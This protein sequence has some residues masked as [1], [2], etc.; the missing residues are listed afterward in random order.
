[1]AKK[2]QIPVQAIFDLVLGYCF[3]VS[4]FV[5][6]NPTPAELALIR[7]GFDGVFNVAQT[8]TRARPLPWCGFSKSDGTIDEKALKQCLQSAFCKLLHYH[9]GRNSAY[10]GTIINATGELNI[11]GKALGLAPHKNIPKYWHLPEGSIEAVEAR[12]LDKENDEAGRRFADLCDTFCQVFQYLKTQGKS[13]SAAG[14]EWRRALGIES[15]AVA[16]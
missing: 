12:K 11:V 6:A 5:E 3:K 16:S 2:P 14:D 10:L 15:P 4:T 13:S 7:K 9:T 8:E 1:M